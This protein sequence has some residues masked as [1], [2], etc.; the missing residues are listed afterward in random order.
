M[1]IIPLSEG[2]FTIDATKRFVPFNSEQ[3]DLQSRSIG[4]LLVEIQP[5]LII[6]SKDILLL[7]TGLGFQKEGESQIKQILQQHQIGAGDITKVLLSHLHKD[8]SG[9]IS[10]INENNERQ[11]TFPNAV[12]YVQE[13]ELRYALDGSSP[14]YLKDEVAILENHSQVEFLRGNGNIDNYITYEI[15]GAHSPFHQVFWIKEEGEVIFYGAD[16]A[17]QLGQMKKR[18]IAKYDYDGRKCMELR[19]QWWRE[20][21]LEKWTFL[22]YHD[23]KTPTFKFE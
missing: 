8:H 11:L 14:S 21:A 5:F 16:D 18:F 19:Q 4:S 12:Y 13:S 22:F 9:A 7:D 10:F 3:D 2:A 1:K 17:P 20:G 6:T 23:V 15:T